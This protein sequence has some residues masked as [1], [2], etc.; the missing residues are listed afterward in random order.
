MITPSF[1]PG[2]ALTVDYWHIK[3]KNVI[4][5]L[6]AQQIVDRCYDD[7]TGINNEFCAA[8]FPPDQQRTTSST[9]SSPVSRAAR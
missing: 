8:V 4:S 1:I 2:L 7:P 5:G 9:W 3:V 6:T